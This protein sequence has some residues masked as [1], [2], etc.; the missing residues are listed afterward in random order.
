MRRERSEDRGAVAI[1][2]AITSV[3]ILGAAA[4]TVD[5]G[6]QRVVR[7]DMQSVA[8]TASLDMAR[9]L[10]RGTAPGTAAWTDALSVSISADTSTLGHATA[11]PTG[12]TAGTAV[13]NTKLCAE[14]TP[15]Y[16]D[17]DSQ[18]TTTAPA[19]AS[20]YGAVRVTTVAAVNR[21]L[22][23]VLGSGDLPASR[24][25]V[26]TSQLPDACYKVGS[27]A[28]DL[29]TN[30]SVLAPLIGDAAAARVLS[31]SGI[32]SAKVPLL[33]LLPEL[34]IGTP[35]ALATAPDITV[36]RLLD[37]SVAALNKQGDTASVSTASQLGLLKT[38]LAASNLLG[39]S[40]SLAKLVDLGQGNMSALNANLEVLDLLT[41][42]L[43]IANGSNAINLP[44]AK[45]DLGALGSLTASLTIVKPPVVGCNGGVATAAQGTIDLKGSLTV[46]GLATLKNVDL[47]VSLANASAVNDT[48][49]PCATSVLNLSVS[50]QTLANV[51]LTADVYAL[52][53]LLQLATIDTGAPQSVPAS[54]YPLPIPG[55]YT[56][57]VIAGSGTLGLSLS[58]ASVK[59]LGVLDAGALVSAL[60]PLVTG[61]SSLLTQ[62][63]LPALGITTAG[64]DLWAL[65]PTPTCGGPKLVG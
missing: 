48:S 16:L 44:D 40:F 13:C 12:W 43:E 11:M 20:A 7:S 52:F 51:R 57:P 14:A 2:V 45:L 28:L 49:L 56:S 17:A 26:A 54:S 50:N 1:I 31:S 34:G 9:A 19:S 35:D 32:A 27:Y 53:G 64:A 63:L 58:G 4:F 5:L 36:G 6:M 10:A 38:D 25:A 3:L 18:F 41:G 62:T 59:L 29:A 23:N 22:G 60:S 30:K 37:A 47:A 24:A 33:G 15:G 39:R 46:A 65:P 21:G 61:V 8:D 42:G 55:S